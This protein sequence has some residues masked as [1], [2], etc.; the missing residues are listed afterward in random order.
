M[1]YEVKIYTLQTLADADP[2]FLPI[3]REYQR[4]PKWR[5]QWRRI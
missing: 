4:G 2:R 1:K 5:C 3:N